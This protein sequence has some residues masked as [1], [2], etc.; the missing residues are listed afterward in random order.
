MKKLVLL[1]AVGVLLLTPVAP[2]NAFCLDF[3][4]RCDGLEL[5]ASGGIITGEWVNYDCIGSNDVVTGSLNGGVAQIVC[6]ADGCDSCV[7]SDSGFNWGFFADGL[8][9]T[10]DMFRSTGSCA[11]FELWIPDL[12]Y[13]GSPGTCDFADKP[14]HLGSSR[15][16]G[17]AS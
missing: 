2:I 14:E 15:T 4:L 3:D 13:T 10:L 9:G 12:E 8:D 16:K 6:G 1:V 11:D 7:V 5:F 17:W